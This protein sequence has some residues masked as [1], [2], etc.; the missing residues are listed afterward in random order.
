[1]PSARG[2]LTSELIAVL[3]EAQARRLVSAFRGQQLYIPSEPIPPDHPLARCLGLEDAQRLQAEYR[4]RYLVIPM[5]RE[6]QR[7]QRNEA[8]IA[9]R[10]KGATVPELSQRFDLS[11]RSIYGILADSKRHFV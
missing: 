1:M 4:G 11:P 6:W 9:A 8:I 7:Q 2:R 10:A 5:G 3:G